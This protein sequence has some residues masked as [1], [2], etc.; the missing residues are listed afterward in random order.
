MAIVA[1]FLLGNVAYIAA[2]YST[3]AK[4]MSLLQVGS[5]YDA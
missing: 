1:A 5:L 3:M 2:I 4:Q